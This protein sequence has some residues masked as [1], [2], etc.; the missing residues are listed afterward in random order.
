[1]QAAQPGATQYIKLEQRLVLLAWLN[2]L[3]GYETNR[4]LL[5]DTRGVSEGF[6]ASGRSYLYHHLEALGDRVKVP[7]AD[8]ARYDDNIRS[9]L[10]A[11]NAG[12]PEPIT[13]RYFQ[14]LAAF[15]TEIFLDRLFRGR[16]E[17]LRALNGFVANRNA[18]RRP[19]ELQDPEF[20]DGD[21][22]K[23]AFWMATGS[24]KTLI[25][26]LNYRQFLHYTDR[27]LD[28]I[29]LVTPNEGLSEQHL[30]EMAASGIPCRRFDLNESGLG[31]DGKNTVR[32]IEIT[33]LVEEKRGGGQ[34]V[35]VEAF[36]GNNLIFV[37]EGHK[38]SGGK[39]WRGYRDALGATGFTFEYSATFGQAL[40]A[41]RNDA[42]AEEY[43]KAIVF[44]YSYRYFHGD[45]YGKDFRILNLR[46][47]AREERTE[48]LMVGNL[49]SFF[50]QKLLYYKQAEVLRPYNL[51]PPLWVFVGSS[52][53]AVFT[54]KKQKRSD[55]LTVVRF[56]H[57]F[58]ENKGGW[59]VKAIKGLLDG[60]SGLSAPDG[61]DLFSGKYRYLRDLDL[62]A[63][64]AYESIL[65]VVFHT[66]AGGVLHLCDMRGSAGELGL[67][68]S[69]AED[70]FGLIYVGDTGAFRKLVEEDEAGIALEEDALSESLFDGIN[71]QDS[72]IEILVGAKKFMEGWNSWRVSNMGLLNIGKGEGSQIIQLFG[73]GVRLRGRDLSLK[74]SSALPDETHPDHIQILETL[75]IFAVRANYM[76]QFRAYLEKEGVETEPPFELRLEIKPDQAFLS[77]G[78]QIPRLPEDLDFAESEFILLE[79]DP[80]VRVRVDLSP[81]A[82]VLTGSTS[83]FTAVAAHSGQDREIPPESLDLVDWNRAYLA[84][85]EYK[86]RRRL[87]NL[88]ILPEVPRT[89]LETIAPAPLYSLRAEEAVFSPARFEDRELVQEA[90]EAI[91]RKYLDAFYRARRERWESHQMVYKV[92]DEDDPNLSFAPP[93]AREAPGKGYV[94]RVPASDDQL[95]KAVE[96]LVKDA[97]K[98]YRK[99]TQ[100]L[101]RVYFDRHVYQ[102]LLVE[103]ADGVTSTPPALKESERT[104]VRDLREYC[105]AEKDG[106]LAKTDIYLLRNLSRGSGIGFFEERGFYPDFILWLV[107]GKRQRIVFVE[108]HGMIHAVAY[109]Y[110]D[111]ARLHESLPD[112]SK[113]MAGRSRRKYVT[114]DS[115]IVSKTP[116]R[117]LHRRYEG[118][119]W[120]RQ[121]FA[122]GHILFQEARSKEYDYIR[123]MVEEQLRKK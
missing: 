92:L 26:H 47:G 103:H 54:Q 39:A 42:L 10:Q 12:R 77:K 40:T 21:L 1:M 121:R 55:V 38:G 117:D 32:V 59:A 31:L 45:G 28:N 33:K 49:L 41:A 98:L 113:E 107:Q 80:K 8:L 13:L 9:H 89:I 67:K 16:R 82:E 2:S 62:G 118:G 115:Y 79:P 20:V 36:E 90:V 37:D 14:H 6:D 43:G 66:G 57:H 61:T 86:Q 116:F 83:G 96:K 108:P 94:V 84:L 46:D 4:G 71:D 69:A 15:Y 91:L 64:D 24:G 73:R 53:N 109:Q 50:E 88:A 18:S 76:S 17:L 104:F 120:N 114:L 75:D 123:M 29:L 58:L 105:A 30:A 95:V 122:D 106:K 19:G 7:F 60:R 65:D 111:K 93:A 11:M 34:S 97:E 48:A 81:K 70:Y 102:P 51:D 99:E 5:A 119:T 101:P 72:P 23:L 110:D 85:V 68:A 56:L 27:T 100:D 35:P 63:R 52:V 22:V 3:L 112:L 74:R 78:L 44:D 25:L 87:G